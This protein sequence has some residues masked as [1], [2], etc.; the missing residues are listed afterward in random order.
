ML[1]HDGCHHAHSLTHD[2]AIR[3]CNY[4]AHAYSTATLA[5]VTRARARCTATAA[6]RASRIPRACSPIQPPCSRA[7]AA[8]GAPPAALRTLPAPTGRGAAGRGGDLRRRGAARQ[9][10]SRG[11]SPPV[12]AAAGGAAGVLIGPFASDGVGF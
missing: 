1:S 12:R 3:R 9:A 8:R 7:R 4:L 11:R 2:V 5:C 6:P 10:L